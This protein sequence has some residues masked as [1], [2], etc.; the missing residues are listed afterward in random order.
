MQQLIT[1]LNLKPHPEGGYF[2]EVFRSEHQ[3]CSPQNGKSRNAMTHIYFLLLAGQKSRFHCVAH[4]EVWNFYAGAPLRLH[5]IRNNQPL[6]ESQSVACDT[7]EIGNSPHFAHVINA[8]HWQAAES[9]GEYSLVGCSV[10]PGFDFE[11]FRFMNKAE[12]DWLSVHQ[13]AWS[14]FV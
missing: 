12:A 6:T 11:D 14:P 1:S 2:S 8:G 13:P 7:I 5:H 4:D 10:A 3:V 9:T